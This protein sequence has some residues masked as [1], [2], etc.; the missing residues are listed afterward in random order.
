MASTVETAARDNGLNI[1]LGA[2]AVAQTLTQQQQREQLERQYQQ[3]YGGTAGSGGANSMNGGSQHGY[4]S[5][6]SL[7]SGS[8]GN[9]SNHNAGNGFAG[10]DDNGKWLLQHR[11]VCKLQSWPSQRRQGSCPC[12]HVPEGHAA[13]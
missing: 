13:S 3:Q 2:K 7:G 6:Q 10:F 1:D 12:C 9:L 4:G 5:S 8:N 11:L